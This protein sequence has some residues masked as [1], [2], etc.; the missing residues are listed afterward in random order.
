MKKSCIWIILVFFLL[1]S[2]TN[3][4]K[5]NIIKLQIAVNIE[6]NNL[7]I[8]GIASDWTNANLISDDPTS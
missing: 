3:M 1:F 5:S 4:S 8:S 6:K 2:M 7:N